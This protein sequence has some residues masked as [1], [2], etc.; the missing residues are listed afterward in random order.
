M[1]RYR[2]EEGQGLVE[3]ALLLVLVAIVI[4]AILAVMGRQVNVVYA[5][6]MAGLNGQTVSG[7]GTEVVVM[8]FGVDVQPAGLVCDVTAS[9]VT[10]AVFEDGELAGSGATVSISAQATGGGAA[11]GAGTTDANGMAALGDITSA[12]ANCSGTLTV[13]ASEKSY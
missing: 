3:Y 9:D 8:S 4:I 1:K 5:R 2:R 12:G 6:V 10:V 11:S 7:S 13:G